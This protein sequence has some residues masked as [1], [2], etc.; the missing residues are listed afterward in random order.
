[1]RLKFYLNNEIKNTGMSNIYLWY[2]ITTGRY[3]FRSFKDTAS[4]E[5]F[6]KEQNT[7]IGE[8]FLI[9]PQNKSPLKFKDIDEFRTFLP[10]L[11]V[12]MNDPQKLA[13]HLLKDVDSIRKKGAKPTFDSMSNIILNKL[14]L[15][16]PNQ[17]QKIRLYLETYKPRQEDFSFFLSIIAI[18]VA[19]IAAFFTKD[20]FPSW[21]E[22]ILGG[23][24][25]CLL[26]MVLP[27]LE[28]YIKAPY[29]TTQIL[30]TY[31]EEVLDQTN[32][33]STV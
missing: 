28:Q 12:D 4:L 3:V 19:A 1:M 32:K 2:C 6:I 8:V 26:I 20:T 22:T 5:S 11:Y 23:I 7:F 31:I 24:V 15:L 25:C 13:E 10:F 17:L 9:T 21:I 18:I 16:P 27:I 29:I 33:E 14:Q 30:L